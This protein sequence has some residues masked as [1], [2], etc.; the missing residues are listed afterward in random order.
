[1]RPKGIRTQQQ[2]ADALGISRTRVIQLERKALAKI[3]AALDLE[4]PYAVKI[5]P[6]GRPKRV[7]R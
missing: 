2:V 4:D 3:C 7:L 6:N 5:S 1:M